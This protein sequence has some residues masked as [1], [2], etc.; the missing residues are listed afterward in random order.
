MPVSVGQVAARAKGEDSAVVGL[1]SGGPRVTG[2]TIRGAPVYTYERAPGVPPVGV[3][4]FW[5]GHLPGGA[6]A[7]EHAHAHEFVVLAYVEHGGGSLRVDGREWTLAAGDAFLIAPGELV[8]QGDVDSAARVW[9]AFFAVDAVGPETLLTWQ[10]HPLLFPFAGRAAGGI[11]R[12]CVPAGQRAAW[13]ARML[14]IEAELG[15]RRDGYADAVLAH[16]TL[17][18][19]DVSRLA[20]DVAGD[21]RIR[22]EPLLADVFAFVE[23]HYAEP[24]SLADV[25]SALGLSGGHLTTVVGR[26]TGRTVGR[27]ITERRMTEARRLLV[28]TNLTVEA[29]GARVGYRDPGYFIRAFRRAHGVTPLR[30][31][32]ADRPPAAPTPA[33]RG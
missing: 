8:T 23:A 9:A 24:I 10:A 20:A 1:S 3:M 31:R 28:E 21:L 7:R 29:I 2:R 13:L 14:A 18:L 12:L 16:L 27:W 11:Q 26:K 19:V 4:R 5:G 32:R 22:D 15:R 33:P 30:W 17:L 25:A 6:E